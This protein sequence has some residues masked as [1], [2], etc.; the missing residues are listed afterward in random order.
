MNLRTLLWHHL[1]FGLWRGFL[2]SILGSAVF[3]LILLLIF[4]ANEA[5]TRGVWPG[6]GDLA[7]VVIP[8]FISFS[9]AVIPGCLGGIVISFAHHIIV[10]RGYPSKVTLLFGLGL[11]GL[12]GGLVAVNAPLYSSAYSILVIPACLVTAECGWWAAK[13]LVSDYERHMLH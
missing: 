4:F 9:A 11:G 10:A 5:L 8:F 6:V 7:L 1:R 2:A 13:R 3:G 12:L